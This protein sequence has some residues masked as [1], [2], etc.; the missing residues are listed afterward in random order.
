MV[1]NNYHAAALLQFIGTQD[2][3]QVHGK[4]V[5]FF[6]NFYIC[7]QVQNGIKCAFGA[8]FVK[9]HRRKMYLIRCCSLLL[10]KE[11]REID[12][13]NCLSFAELHRLNRM[14]IQKRIG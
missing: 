12:Q 2:S 14:N 5:E 7:L 6:H 11:G 1:S 4:R 9:C 10:R 13:S 3:R 8:F